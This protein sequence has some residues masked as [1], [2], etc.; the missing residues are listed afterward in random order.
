MWS[1]LGAE[2]MSVT[3]WYAVCA[4]IGGAVLLTQFAL[5]VLGLDG[6]DDV[7]ESPGVGGGGGGDGAAD[8]VGL[9]SLKTLAAALTFFGLTGLALG[10]AGWSPNLSLLGAMAAGLG[11]MYGVWYLMLQLMRLRSDGTIRTE[12][13]IG[14]TATVYL[15]IP[16]HNQGMGKVTLRLQNRSC[17][18]AAVTP[19]GDLPRGTSVV[20]TRLFDPETVEVLPLSS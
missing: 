5:S 20:V 3:V 16:G 18:L 2:S 9:L 1:Q 12:R 15:P 4:V 11:A 8:I 10:A 13:A 14:K 6:A 17:E 19:E 7:P